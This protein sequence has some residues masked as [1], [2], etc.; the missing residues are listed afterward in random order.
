MNGRR[1]LVDVNVPMYAAGQPHSYRD[2]CVWIMTEIAEGRLAG[3][4][5]AEIVQEVLYRYGSL[6]Q[7]S[8]AVA[9][10][11]SLF[12]LFPTVLPV[13]PADAKRAITLFEEYG[14]R[15]VAARDVIHV[16]VMESNDLTE[17]ISTDQHF[18]QIA[19][20]TRWDPM[21]LFSRTIAT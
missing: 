4:I 12:D 5:D 9:M 13:L 3:A 16:A 20:I 17:I 18:D 6:R 21:A 8:V 1:V 14:P 2:S 11:T 7:W 15:G 19:G 10:A